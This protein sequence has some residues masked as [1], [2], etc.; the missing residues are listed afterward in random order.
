MK[1]V[2]ADS[3]QSE[4]Q[5]DLEVYL[6]SVS[7][8]SEPPNMCSCVDAKT[9]STTALCALFPV[10]LEIFPKLFS[11]LVVQDSTVGACRNRFV[12]ATQLKYLCTME[13]ASSVVGRTKKELS[14]SWNG[15]SPYMSTEVFS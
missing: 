6:R 3:G 7:F 10:S 15:G 12:P 11:Q 8:L 9:I 14:T 5:G 2:K 13:R 4:L 1:I